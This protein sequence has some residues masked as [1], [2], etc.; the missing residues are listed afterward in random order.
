LYLVKNILLLSYVNILV[1]ITRPV[2][3]SIWLLKCL[4]L[5]KF[6]ELHDKAWHSILSF[7]ADSLRKVGQPPI[8]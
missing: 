3:K 1:H 8:K 4:A 6:R 7:E 5:I 2:D